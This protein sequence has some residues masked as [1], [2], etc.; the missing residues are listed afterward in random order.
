MTE[1]ILQPLEMKRSGFVVTEELKKSLAT[2][3]RAADVSGTHAVAP[4]A[5]HGQASGMLYSSV[6][7]IAEY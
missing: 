1:H 4:Y 5:A 7:D 6:E 3:Y 2:G